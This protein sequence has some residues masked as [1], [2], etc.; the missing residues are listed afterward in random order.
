MSTQHHKYE[1]SATPQHAA[2]KVMRMV[3]EGKRVL[4]LGSGP[5]S[6]TRLFADN[7][8]RITA[9]E[10]DP[11][12]IK[13]VS[14]YCEHVHSCDLND[15]NWPSVLKGVDKFE[16]IVAGDVLEHLYDPWST[17]ESLRGFL[18]DDGYVVISLPHTGHNAIVACLL[19]G[20]FDYQPWGL[21]DKTHIRFFGIKNI[22][23]MFNNA[24]LKITEV[25]FVVKSPE[26][27]E[28]AKQWRQLSANTRQALSCNKFGNV[29][30]VV[31]KAKPRT[32][33]GKGLQI[34]SQ[35]VPEPQRTPP[36]SGLKENPAVKYIVSHLSLKTRENIAH[37]LA[38]LGLKF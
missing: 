16:V 23:D 20:A 35:V 22:Q 3:G 30:Q 25:D 14:Q 18:V 28:F 13:I 11:E 34:S 12:A 21:L 32:S 26:Q 33:S 7:D 6:M 38:K 24:G 17:L 15:N 1:Y 27:T 19:S 29:Y 5:G 8:C 9:L 37:F 2:T 36:G 4:E 31:V 10:L